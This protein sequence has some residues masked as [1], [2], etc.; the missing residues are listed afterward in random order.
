MHSRSATADLVPH[1]DDAVA[2]APPDH[3]AGEAPVENRKASR[4][5]TWQLPRAT[6][7][8]LSPQGGP[9]ILVNLSASGALVQC[10]SRIALETRLSLVFEGTT[11]PIAIPGRVVRSNVAAI[12]AEGNLRFD[13]GIAFTRDLSPEVWREVAG[14]DEV[15]DEPAAP[16][17]VPRRE[18]RW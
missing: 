2:D 1:T 14:G 3:A 10:S 17:A 6:P 12:D 5:P 18:N 13:V 15:R 7:V 11:T 16:P 8:R 9:A 4:L